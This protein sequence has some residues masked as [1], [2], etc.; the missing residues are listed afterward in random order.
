MG[1]DK[2]LLEPGGLL[3]NR[4]EVVRKLAAGG[5]ATIY[6]VRHLGLHSLHALKV[7]DPR[8]FH[9]ADARHRFTTEGRIQALLRHPHIAQVTD[10]VISPVPGLVMEYVEG[11]TLEDLLGQSP[12]GRLGLPALRQIFLPVLDAMHEAHGHR[13]VHRDLT[14]SNILL[15]QGHQGRMHPKVTDFGIAKVTQDE[16]GEKYRTRTGVL[17]GTRPYM[18]PEQIGG[19]SDVDAR[20]DIFALGTILYEAATGRVAFD[21]GSDFEM[22]KRITE[23][24]FTPPEQVVPEL[25]EGLCQCIRKAM[26]VDPAGRFQDCAAFRAA[27]EQA[28]E[29]PVPKPIPPETVAPVPAPTPVPAPPSRGRGLITGLVLLGVL[30]VLLLAGL[31]SSLRHLHLVSGDNASLQARYQTEQQ[32]T[33]RLKQ[34]LD[35][36][37]SQARSSEAQARDLQTR[38]Q[39]ALQQLQQNE[40]L[41]EE[42]QTFQQQA[43]KFLEM[44]LL[45]TSVRN[46]D[47]PVSRAVRTCNKT[48]IVLSYQYMNDERNWSEALVLEPG[49]CLSHWLPGYHAQVP[50][51]IT[52]LRDNLTVED[53]ALAGMVVGRV[54]DTDVD[55]KP[56]ENQIVLGQDQ[57]LQLKPVFLETGLLGGVSHDE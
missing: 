46:N 30:S 8:I 21:A 7:P 56:W 22:M 5:M 13:V 17:L 19:A 38:N 20:T 47:L 41:K 50:V 3:D 11:G 48:G 57:V 39:G 52:S 9:S 31:A 6:L 43:L 10:I 42:L 1:E 51:R 4:Y 18:S 23:G 15:A 35:I 40:Q 28:L 33:R 55:W 36:A 54:P 12:G 2:S 26:T 27:L 37:R 14:P 49:R 25:P 16:P 32:N 44:T 29:E 24:N 34:E 45:D 53:K